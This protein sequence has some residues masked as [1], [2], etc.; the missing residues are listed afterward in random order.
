MT[1]RS[2]GACRDLAMAPQLAGNG[3]SP[4]SV[5]PGAGWFPRPCLGKPDLSPP[6]ADAHFTGGQT[7][8][9]EGILQWSGSSLSRPLTPF[10]CICALPHSCQHS[11]LLFWSCS[12]QYPLLHPSIIWVEARKRPLPTELTSARAVGGLNGQE[13]METWG[14]LDPR[15]LEHEQGSQATARHLLTSL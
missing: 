13:A 10:T 15:A 12:Q 6:V 14:T 8:R 1:T 4:L 7:R 9:A 2:C 5:L 11:F 3:Q